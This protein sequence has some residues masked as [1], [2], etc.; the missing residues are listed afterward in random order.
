MP[1]ANRLHY[2]YSDYLRSLEMS[3]PKLELRDGVIDATAGGTRA[4]GADDV[5]EGITL[6][7]T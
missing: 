2:S 4:C 6:D 3:E 5:D 1:T 7:P